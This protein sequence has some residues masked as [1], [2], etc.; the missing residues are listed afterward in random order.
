MDFMRILSRS[1][2]RRNNPIRTD[3]M[4]N[5]DRPIEI[6]TIQYLKCHICGKRHFHSYSHK[7]SEYMVLCLDCGQEYKVVENLKTLFD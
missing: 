5:Q 7:E 4:K 3:K 2:N 1:S 6:K